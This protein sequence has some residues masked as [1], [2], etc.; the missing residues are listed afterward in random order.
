VTSINQR[1]QNGNLINYGNHSFNL[2][3]I[4][5]FYLQSGCFNPYSTCHR[6]HFNN[7]LAVETSVQTLLAVPLVSKTL[8]L[9]NNDKA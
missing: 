7:Y 8:R 4:G 9:G 6:G 3:V 5:F 1:R 2:V